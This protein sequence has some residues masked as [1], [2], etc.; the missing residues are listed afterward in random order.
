MGIL[1]IIIIA[2]LVVAGVGAA[3]YF[4]LFKSKHKKEAAENAD[5]SNVPSY[6]MPAP[7]S[8][9]N[10]PVPDNFDATQQTQGTNVMAQSQAPVMNDIVGSQPPMS[11]PEAPQ[12]PIAPMQSQE[13]PMVNHD[14]PSQTDFDNVSSGT[15]NTPV[16]QDSNIS[17]A[18]GTSPLE[19]NLTGSLMDN[20]QSAVSPTPQQSID[21]SVD[22]G[23]ADATVPVTKEDEHL[24]QVEAEV[25]DTE[26]SEVPPVTEEN[27]AP[28]TVP[29]ENSAFV[30]DTT[31]VPEVNPGVQ[32]DVGGQDSDLTPS[33]PPVADTLQSSPQAVPQAPEPANDTVVATSPVASE[34]QSIPQSVDTAP[35]PINNESSGDQEN[36]A[37]E[38]QI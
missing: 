22:S 34:P 9:V 1:I 28:Q 35:S 32:G 3:A 4:L 2:L 26:I 30:P 33:T 5:Y 17:N 24:S 18:G 13:Q 10:A 27:N 20:E 11:A 29:T 19:A 8:Q 31:Y 15:D 14:F 25:N 38:M 23:I 37:K 7:D 16:A 21:D 6:G 36:Q 12:P